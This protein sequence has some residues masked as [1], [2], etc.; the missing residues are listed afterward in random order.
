MIGTRE[1]S[2]T[3]NGNFG[4]IYSHD[5]VSNPGDCSTWYYCADLKEGQTT[6]KSWFP[7]NELKITK[8]GTPEHVKV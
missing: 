7:A 6:T 4:G 1:V 2:K 8:I 5:Q 3:S